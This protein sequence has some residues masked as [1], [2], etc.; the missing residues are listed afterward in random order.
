[1][2]TYIHQNAGQAVAPEDEASLETSTFLGL[3]YPDAGLG[4]ISHAQQQSLVMQVTA[5]SNPERQ[6]LQRFILKR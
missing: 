2:F 6:Q 5:Y 3:L 4:D 1:M